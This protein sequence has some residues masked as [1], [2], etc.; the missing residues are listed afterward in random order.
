MKILIVDD[1]PVV[2]EGVRR[3][4]EEQV[5]GADVA[6]AATGQEALAR[7]AE[8]G[9]EAVLLDISLGSESG[10]DLLADIK[11]LC[12][13][14]PVLVLTMHSEEQYARR[15]LKSG[16]SGY[17]TKDTSRA[18]LVDALRTVVEGRT[19]ISPALAERLAAD[20][21]SSA[22]G[23]AHD[24]LSPREFQVMRLLGSGRTVTQ[25]A[26]QLRLSDKTVSTYRS[27]VLEKLGLT[28]S[29]E[30][31]RYALENKLIE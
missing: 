25:I 1:H 29:A 18:V 10:I 27:R 26:E 7:L 28:T 13:S 11:A 17:V 20:V 3:I 23:I 30:L 4:L 12:P 8:N 19:Y 31:I 22:A 9:W 16:A 2:R 5:P 14:V 15:V 21:R 6:G 24:A